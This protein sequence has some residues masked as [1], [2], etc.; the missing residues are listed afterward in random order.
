MPDAESAFMVLCMREADAVHADVLK[1][2]AEQVQDWQAVVELAERHR[3]LA[4]VRRALTR[5]GLRIDPQA[6]CALGSKLLR[7]GHAAIVQQHF[8]CQLSERLQTANVP[9][10]VLKGPVPAPL[11]YPSAVFRPSADLDIEVRIADVDATSA[12]LEETGLREYDFDR[13]LRGMSTRSTCT[14]ARPSTES[15][16]RTMVRYWWS[17]TSTPCSWGFGFSRRSAMA[18][19]CRGSQRTGVLMLSLA[20]QLVHL[21]VHIQKHGFNRL[22]WLKDIDLLLRMG[23]EADWRCAVEIARQEGVTA[24]VWYTLDIVKKM[25]GTPIPQSLIQQL[26]PWLV[27]RTVYRCVWPTRG[28]V[29]LRGHMRR[30]AAQFHVADSWRGMLPSLV[31]LGH[32]RQRLRSIADAV[33][34]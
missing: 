7:L 33:F 23:T 11:L 3:A 13:R 26:Q 9:L 31:L 22:I 8:L 24:S 14:A 27:L 4:Y 32:R 10:L 20:D 16:L 6:E 12:A 25:L 2:A 29:S 1:A 5:L 28:I 19:G 21:S 17:C 30:R 18:A 34:H 15:F